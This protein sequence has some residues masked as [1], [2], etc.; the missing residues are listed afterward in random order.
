MSEER[1]FTELLTLHF[2]PIRSLTPLEIGSLFRHYELMVRWNSVLNLTSIRRLEDVVIRHYCESLFL[3]VHLPETPVSVLDVGSG[4]GFPAIPMA[5]LRPD[6]RFTLCESRQRKAVFLREA[7]RAYSHVNVEA[8]RAEEVSGSFDWAVSRAVRWEQVVALPHRSIGL[9]LG[10]QDA[11]A[12][13]STAG[14]DWQP[15][16]R[17]PW[18][19]HRVLVYGTRSRA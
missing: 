17:L 8:C 1:E 19:R 13:T 12:V 2:G 18:G 9:L 11:A 10:E 7:A 6:C 4:A 15:P 3:A 16:V 14:F 5:V